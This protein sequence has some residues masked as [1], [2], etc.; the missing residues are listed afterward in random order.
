MEEMLTIMR[1]SDLI[2]SKQGG[3]PG[4]T[5]GGHSLMSIIVMG[6]EATKIMSQHKLKVGG[7]GLVALVEVFL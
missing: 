6:K 1:A 7:I 2:D 5:R 3:T 4:G